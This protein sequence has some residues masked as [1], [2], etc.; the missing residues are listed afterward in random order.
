MSGGVA[1]ASRKFSLYWWFIVEVVEYTR[2][3][4][5]GRNGE[6]GYFAVSFCKK[7]FALSRT[8]DMDCSKLN[9]GVGCCRCV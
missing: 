6:N 5:E 2:H 3:R 4:L 1:A 9:I 7:S 8:S